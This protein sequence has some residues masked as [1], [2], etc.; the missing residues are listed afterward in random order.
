M[1]AHLAAA[2]AALALAATSAIAS[3]APSL[4]TRVQSLNP[5]ISVLQ[6]RHEPLFEP[7][8]RALSNAKRLALGLP[9][10]PPR[11]RR[12][13]WQLEAPRSLPSSMPLPAATGYIKLLNADTGAELGLLAAGWNSFGEYGT[14]T[15][16]TANALGVKIDITAAALGAA[17]ITALNSPNPSYPFVGAIS[18]FSSASPDLRAGSS[19]YAYVGGT[20]Q[21]PPY[22]P[23]ASPGNSFTAATNIPEQSESAIFK[24][25][26][27]TKAIAV[28]YVNVD[29]S[30]PATYLGLTQ[31]V[32][33]LTGDKVAFTNTFGPTVWVAL[34]FV[35]A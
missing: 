31:G 16:S 34:E 2:A 17:D 5:P 6:E 25:N 28:Q 35:P 29:S 8:D 32:L 18:G 11:P 33:V 30:R 1:L 9:L 12:E 26:P 10:L 21:T 14:V 27:I 7:E 4:T 13:G 3:P 20:K 22:S 23:P 15:P 24:Y 19:N